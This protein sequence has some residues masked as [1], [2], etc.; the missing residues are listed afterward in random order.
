[1]RLEATGLNRLQR[2]DAMLFRGSIAPMAALSGHT[3]GYLA[4]MSPADV[5][6]Q[7]PAFRLPLVAIFDWASVSKQCSAASKQTG[8]VF[9][10]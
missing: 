6:Q 8:Q 9:R 2:P 10:I 4:T 3:E 1:M 7:F 5:V